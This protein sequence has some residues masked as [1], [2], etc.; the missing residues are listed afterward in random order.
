MSDQTAPQPLPRT[1]EREALGAMGGYNYQIWRSIES[2]L[3][4]P[5]N[6]VLFL[7]GAE[8]IDRVGASE[9]TTVQVKQRQDSLS[10]N[11]E[12]ARDAIR[13]F[14]TTTTRSP[15]RRI[16]FVYLSTSD[17][18]LE[19]NAQFGGLKGI[20]AWAKAEFDPV[21]ADA[22]RNQLLASFE[23]DEPIAE[24]LATAPVADL[25]AKLFSR[26][27]WLMQQDNVEVVEQCVLERIVDLLLARQQPRSA[28]AVVKKALFEFCWKQV[29][30]EL[31]ADRR[32][33]RALLDDQ[34]SAATTITLE[35]PLGSSAGLV[36]AAAQLPMLQGMAASFALLQ[37]S[38]PSPPKY[39]LQRPSLVEQVQ[40]IVSQRSAILLAGSVFMGKTT[41][42]Q[43]VA[44]DCGLRG[45]WTELSQRPPAAVAEAF[46]LLALTLDR[47]GGPDLLIFDDLDTSPLARRTYATNLRQ[48]LHRAEVAGKALLFT[49]QGHSQS[50]EREVAESW[51]IQVVQVPEMPVEEVTAHCSARG[52]PAERAKSWGAIVHLQSS[53]HPALVQVRLNELAAEG[54]VHGN[55]DSLLTTTQATRDV[56]QQARELAG[57]TFEPAEVQFA[58]EAAEFVIRPT[59]KML[60]TLAGLPPPLAGAPAVISK[61]TGRWI[62]ELGGDRFRVTQVLRGEL[63]VT[64]T[65]NQYRD[66]HR[67]IFDSI[68]ASSPL[69]ATDGAATVFHAFMARDTGRFVHSAYQIL[70]AEEP[71]RAQLLKQCVWVLGVQTTPSAA[72]EALDEQLPSLRHLQFVV[73]ATEDPS[74]AEEVAQAWR[75]AVGPRGNDPRSKLSRGMYDVTV[76]T[77]YVPVSMETALDAIGSLMTAD[78][79]IMSLLEGGLQSLQH[80]DEVRALV[81]PKD[82]TSFQVLISFYAGRVRTIEDVRALVSWLETPENESYRLEFDQVFEWPYVAEA[83]GFVHGGW[84]QESQNKMPDWAS[85]L[86]VLGAALKSCRQLGLKG[87]AVQLARAK[88]IILDEYIE[89][90]SAAVDVL[91]EVEND[92]G[93]SPVL[94]EQRVNILWRSG[95]HEAAMNEWDR[96]GGDVSEHSAFDVFSWRRAAISSG[97]TKQFARAIELFEAAL[98][99]SGG[100]FDPT[101]V[102]LLVD[103]A[104]CAY[105]A[106]DR[107]RCSA[108][109]A[110]AAGALPEEARHDGE[111]KWEAIVQVC[112]VVAQL[113]TGSNTRWDSG[114]PL[115]IPIG[116]AS[117]PG[118]TV[119]TSLP[120][121]AYRVDCFE[122]QVA[123]LEAEFADADP[124][125]VARGHELLKSSSEI[126]RLYSAAA[127]S[128]HVLVASKPGLPSNAL[129]LLAA[130]DAM[131]AGTTG[132]P[133]LNLEVPPEMMLRGLLVLGLL[134]SRL[135]PLE[136]LTLWDA[137]AKGLSSEAL[138]HELAKLRVGLSM[139][140]NEA[141]DEATGFTSRDETICFGAAVQVCRSSDVNMRSLVYASIRIS[142]ALKV[143]VVIFMAAGLRTCVAKYFATRLARHLQLPAQFRVPSLTLPALAEAIREVERG[144]ADLK[145]LLSVASKAAGAEVGDALDKV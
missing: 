107:R 63:N 78:D 111:R 92:L 73:T 141:V 7:E 125:V 80:Q 41:I 115:A 62:E 69:T 131:K 37:D 10:L 130:S 100:G 119:E 139:S 19:R 109:L 23:A 53:G 137:E 39:L 6:E 60:L 1:P 57:S 123:L 95:Q 36:M 126:P 103:A 27:K 34:I 128:M 82:A 13:N 18:A 65:E 135:E 68:V 120:G 134:L 142:R 47:P 97:M 29:L 143:G 88:S 17:L 127:A 138:R 102:G 30:K 26:F 83:G 61:L 94:D 112:N 76:L 110:R 72:V 84:L 101:R 98:S 3:T 70:T 56:K 145:V 42:A 81:P 90:H 86:E 129:A 44:R 4:L 77:T 55:P 136:L 43:V 21:L 144:V 75:R 52:C 14:W 96:L 38:P 59:R 122:A 106:K 58:L 99:R 48:L 117:A 9:T 118:F 49:A 20:Q 85:W 105:L 25:Q 71:L 91:V 54:W 87:Y 133:D 16:S 104:Y 74:R 116:R 132:N 5:A 113:A 124:R 24:F 140:I 32:L 51:G 45:A 64:W 79:E 40:R 35:L 31:P 15:E 66:V 108:L 2:W 121:Q 22:V 8:D 28:A 33:D 93:T 46:K 67:K 114:A 89:D 12:S 11:S 50:L